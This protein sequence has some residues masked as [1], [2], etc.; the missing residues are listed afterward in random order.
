MKLEIIDDK[1]I[2]LALLLSIQKNIQQFIPTLLSD[3]G[4]IG[5]KEELIFKSFIS[6]AKISN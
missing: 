1:R 4:K 6:F 2:W 3:I 5:L